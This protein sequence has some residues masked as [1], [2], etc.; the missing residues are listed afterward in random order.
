[1]SFTSVTNADV[2]EIVKELRA[3]IANGD[4]QNISTHVIERILALCESVNGS[5]LT[6]VT[7]DDFQDGRPVGS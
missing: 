7:E 1:M 2:T 6:N 3:A 5:G 4:K